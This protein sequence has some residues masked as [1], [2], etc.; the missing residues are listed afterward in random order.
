VTDPS[1]D[2][3]SNKEAAKISGKRTADAVSRK[4]W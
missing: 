3:S 1:R 2:R 4:A